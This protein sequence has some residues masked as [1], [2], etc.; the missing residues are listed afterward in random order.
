M[1][2]L[3]G[4]EKDCL[5]PHECINGL[6]RPY[7]KKLKINVKLKLKEQIKSLKLMN[8]KFKSK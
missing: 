2:I 8:E 5:S 6:N 3:S 4:G 1:I 7:K